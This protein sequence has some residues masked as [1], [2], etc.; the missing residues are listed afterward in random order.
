MKGKY[1]NAPQSKGE[2]KNLVDQVTDDMMG[3][4]SSCSGELQKMYNKMTAVS[5]IFE[6][7][8]AI[9]SRKKNIF[10]HRKERVT[11]S[12]KIQVPTLV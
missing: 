6:T 1:Q 12:V 4:F 3:C 9:M 11:K 5:K 7:K 2:C 10:R 8:P